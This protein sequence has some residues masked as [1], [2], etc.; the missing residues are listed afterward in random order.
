[1]SGQVTEGWKALRNARDAFPENLELLHFEAALQRTYKRADKA[2]AL[3]YE[4]IRLTST[5]ES[6]DKKIDPV[7]A[8][9]SARLNIAEIFLEQGK[10]D[11]ARELW[12]AVLEE[13]PENRQAKNRLEKAD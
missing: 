8:R 1:M 5:H 9:N 11:Q 6:T 10:D 4:I 3:W 13:I 12:K 7:A 2:T